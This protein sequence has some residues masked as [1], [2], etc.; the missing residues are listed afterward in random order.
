[1][2]D[3]IA[4]SKLLS[5][6]LRH[7]PEHFN[8]V[9]DREGWVAIDKLIAG[10]D[11]RG[12]F[13]SFSKLIE[14]VDGDRKKRFE[15]SIDGL[16]VRAVQGHSV[17]SV[18]RVFVELN[19]PS[20]LYHGTAERFL[21]SICQGGIVA[22][23]R[24]YVHLTSDKNVA[25]EVGR[26]YGEVVVLEISAQ[27]MISHGYKFYKAENDVWLVRWVPPQFILGWAE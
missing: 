10:A 11:R 1:M 5:Y 13:I 20:T 16:K 15:V 24:Q 19:P 22:G 21:D 18:D 27:S 14:V 12:C 2:E 9:L 26:R 6:V 25:L 4:V 17:K 8:V 3:D 7:C 23:V